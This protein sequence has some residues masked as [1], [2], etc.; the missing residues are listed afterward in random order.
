M[1]ANLST[2]VDRLEVQRTGPSDTQMKEEGDKFL[3]KMQD[4]A[5][6]FT[7]ADRDMSPEDY[8]SMLTSRK[9]CEPP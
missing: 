6:R 7:E 9:M 1:R 2:R 4:I 5:D 3:K 8:D